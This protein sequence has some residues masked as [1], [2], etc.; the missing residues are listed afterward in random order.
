MRNCASVAP[1]ACAPY[2]ARTKGKDERAVQY[3]KRNALAGLE[4][5]HPRQAQM[6]VM[7]FFGGMTIAEIAEVFGVTPRTMKTDW[8]MARAWLKR[9]LSG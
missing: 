7:R 6:V 2:R 1:R 5:L 3:V 9:E 4:A 8:A